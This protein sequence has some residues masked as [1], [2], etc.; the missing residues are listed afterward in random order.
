MFASDSS[1]DKFLVKLNNWC[2]YEGCEARRN[3][4]LKKREERDERK[5]LEKVAKKARKDFVANKPARVNEAEAFVPQK[6]EPG[7]QRAPGT[8]SLFPGAWNDHLERE[9]QRR[10]L[11]DNWMTK[12]DI[13]NYR[14]LWNEEESQEIGAWK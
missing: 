4:R 9:W 2:W 10:I 1:F 12:F 11:S 5:R 7:T 6:R 3:V 14:G 8:C 13:K